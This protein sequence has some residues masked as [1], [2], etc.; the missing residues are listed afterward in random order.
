[1]VHS[2]ACN[3][4]ENCVFR[5]MYYNKTKEV[6]KTLRQQGSNQGLLFGLGKGN[7]KICK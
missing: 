3:N 4:G 2:L 1:M 5:N 6:N 7:M